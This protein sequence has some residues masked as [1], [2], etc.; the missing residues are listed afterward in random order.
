MP[1][2]PRFMLMNLTALK[3][4]PYEVQRR[5]RGALPDF[6]AVADQPQSRVSAAHHARRV[7]STPSPP[8]FLASSHRGLRYR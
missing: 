3:L 6:G 4:S 7:Q 2:L 1:N 8:V 5:L